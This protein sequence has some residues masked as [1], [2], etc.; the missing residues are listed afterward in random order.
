[1][2][3][4]LKFAI[5]KIKG[6]D[7]MASVDW[8]KLHTPQDVKQV[9]R[10]CDRDCRL[11]DNH[12]NE[13]IDK[14]MTTYNLQ[15]C[16]YATACKRY[17]DRIAYLDSLPKH[18][19]RADRVTA[20]GLEIPIP[21]EIPNERVGEYANKVNKIITNLHGKENMLSSYVHVDEVHDYID[22]RTKQNRTSMRHIHTFFIPEHDNKLNAKV[23]CSK[24]S[25][26]E[27]NKAVDEMTRNDYGISFLTGDYDKTQSKQSVER[28]KLESLKLEL[29]QREQNVEGR[30][31]A[32][33]H[34]EIE[35]NKREKLLNQ[36]KSE[37]DIVYK[38]AYKK[39]SEAD[40]KLSEVTKREQ[41][42]AR[43]EM[44]VKQ[45]ENAMVIQ[46]AALQRRAD[47]LEESERKLEE[48]KQN[49]NAEVRKAAEKLLDRQKQAASMDD[50][51]QK[52]RQAERLAALPSF[53]D[54]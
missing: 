25:M 4:N 12:D 47:E 19:K 30:E 40:R 7:W 13:N 48:R 44:S 53:D 17:D 11:Q 52:K 45:S 15:N 36:Q 16:D 22:S 21:D 38:S 3:E 23:V 29:E 31:E 9:M 41:D 1:M 43:R 6:S 46:N 18:N 42:V 20:I 2:Q 37:I 5:I 54:E 8:K 51:F 50:E 39:L 28:L 49:F 24:K 26:I 27:I 32:V 10:H 35:I 34:D 33:A 14:S